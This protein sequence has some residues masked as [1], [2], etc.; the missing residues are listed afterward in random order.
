[1]FNKTACLLAPGW[2]GHHPCH[3][4]RCV[5]RDVDALVLDCLEH[6]SLGHQGCHIERRVAKNGND[7]KVVGT[8][9]DDDKA[10]CD[11]TLL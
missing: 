9:L 6:R 11:G 10:A 2:D 1:M 4:D 5:R 8:I 7:T 3:A